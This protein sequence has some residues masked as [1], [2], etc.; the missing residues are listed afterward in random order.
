MQRQRRR[1]FLLHARARANAPAAAHTPTRTL[2]K[3]EALGIVHRCH[4]VAPHAFFRL[5]LWQDE[6]V[7]ACVARWQPACLT[8]T[9]YQH[10]ELAKAP[11]R[12]S[13]AAGDEREE[14]LLLLERQRVQ[15]APEALNRCV[16]GAVSAL[17]DRRLL[18]RVEIEVGQAAHK[19]L[20][21]VVVEQHER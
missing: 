9:L 13:I 20:E 8:R 21:L 11:H 4:E 14:L 17:V 7:E 18:Q 15:N 10:L 6:H 16:L 12:R 5:I 19:Q 1:T 2:L 3:T